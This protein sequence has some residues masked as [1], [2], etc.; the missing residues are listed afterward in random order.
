[1]PSPFPGMD[2]Y[3][4]GYL[5]ADV[6]HRLATKI[7]QQLAP[8]IQP[9]YVARLELSVIEDE[10]FESEIGVMYPDVEIIRTRPDPVGA[11]TVLEPVA[12]VAPLT[13]R[14]PRV[15]LVNVEIR[16]TAEN[17]LVTSIEILSPVNKRAP[18]L[19]KYRTKRDR[20][21]RA[22]V[23][24]LELDLLRR[25]SRVWQSTQIPQTDYIIALTRATAEVMAVWPL[26]I[27]E[28]LPILPVPLRYPDKD[29]L[30]E[31]GRALTEVYDEAY[32]HL[33]IDY[34]TAPP[35]PAIAKENQAWI[36]MLLDGYDSD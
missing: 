7:S 1:M 16:D 30:L 11:G 2:P 35:P 32:Y 9:N 36:R 22:E 21:K 20:L 17:K 24:L 31:L 13:I 26:T 29:V 4:E 10:T 12:T 15:K 34:Q 5:W 8:Q 19:A 18:N 23:H 25:G 6:H 14:V 33:S 28:V 3:L 27:Q